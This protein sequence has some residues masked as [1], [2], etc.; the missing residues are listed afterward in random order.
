MEGMEGPVMGI[1]LSARGTPVSIF[2]YKTHADLSSRLI[3]ECLQ[4]LT[5]KTRKKNLECRGPIML[6]VVVN[7]YEYKELV[8]IFSGVWSTG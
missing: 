5:E 7:C 8:W 4:S 1:E 3:E 2:S 6:L